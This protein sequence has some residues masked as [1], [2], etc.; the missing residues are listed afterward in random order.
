MKLAGLPRSSRQRVAAVLLA[1]AASIGCTKPADAPVARGPAVE[2]APAERQTVSDDGDESVVDFY[3]PL[4]AWGDW[5]EDAQYG[6]VWAPSAQIVG[7][8]FAPY[9]SGGSWISTDAGWV[10]QSPWDA[11]WGWAAFH[12]GRWY[13]SDAQ[14][15]VWVPDVVW[16]PSWVDWR[17]GGDHVGWAPTAPVGL[18]AA[19]EGY[20][21][22][23]TRRLLD[24]SVAAAVV[25]ADKVR[26][27]YTETQPSHEYRTH[28]RVRW[29]LGPPASH[30]AAA[31]L[32]VQPTHYVVPGPGDLRKQARIAAT[33]AVV[34][35][36]RKKAQPQTPAA[37]PKPAAAPTRPSRQRP[38]R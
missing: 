6:T 3:G 35:G 29:P 25:P 10:F 5:V 22:V 20:S 17:H 23:E 19:P 26:A 38:S 21:F 37:T 32:V 11:A 30:L 13:D 14:G 36:T 28:G 18:T 24:R 4:A 1:G 9:T 2:P 15:W 16:G 12:Y 33:R 8:D 34:A 31:G 7:A 27:V